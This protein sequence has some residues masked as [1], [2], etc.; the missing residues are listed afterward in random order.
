MKNLL[1]YYGWLNSFNSAVH[2][3]INE[4]VSKE[5]AQYGLLV[6]GDGLQLDTHGDYSN[7][8]EIIPRIQELNPRTL[9]FGYVTV[10]QTYSNFK[11]K[12]DD[13]NTLGV[14]G[15]FFDEAGF[16]YGSASTNGRAAFN[17]KVDYVHS[18]GLLCFINSWKPKYVMG[19]EDDGSYP[20]TTW[21][22]DLL[23]SNLNCDD[24]FLM[25]S[26]A[27][28]SAPAFESKTQW[29]DRGNGIQDYMDDIN[30]AACSVI[31][32]TD[33]NGQD[34]FDFI[35]TSAH[36]WALGAVGSSDALYGASSAKS[37][38]WDRTDVNKTRW[39]GTDEPVIKT[40]SG[41]SDV[42]MR[43]L[44]HGIMSLDFSTGSELSAITD[45][46]G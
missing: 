4:K 17:E 32:D 31:S 7:T 5:F 29:Y 38:M 46:E 30:V 44:S 37:K 18:K 11:D 27:I 36:M 20:N 13:W 22:P 12:V 28:T 19:T 10:N 1:I 35:W 8:E 33:G 42:Y 41:D 43:Y 24:W 6:F 15:C 23:E 21:N 2:G 40:D 39:D 14:A 3:W 16:D 9:I 26:F 45:Y 34:K 25:E